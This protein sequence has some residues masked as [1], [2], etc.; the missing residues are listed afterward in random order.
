MPTIKNLSSS[1]NEIEF[2]AKDLLSEKDKKK[3]QN[4]LLQG[5]SQENAED[6]R[7]FLLNL[8]DMT[9][10]YLTEY[11]RAWAYFNN[12]FEIEKTVE[13]N[14]PIDDSLDKDEKE[15]QMMK[16]YR[17]WSNQQGKVAAAKRFAKVL[18]KG[19][20]ILE[21]IR[22]SLT[23]QTL[24][25]VFY[26]KDSKNNVK[27][28]DKAQI[29]PKIVFSTFG[30]SGNNFV[31][32]AYHLPDTV[33]KTYNQIEEDSN[34]LD[35][36]NEIHTKIMNLKPA[37]LN[38]KYGNEHNYISRFDSKDAEIMEMYL[39]NKDSML[40][41]SLDVERY[42]LLRQSVGGGGGQRST[43]LQSGDIGLTQVKMFGSN[44]D[45]NFLRQTLVYK[46]FSDIANALN[47]L[48]NINTQRLE[49]VFLKMF[50]NKYKS[51]TNDLGDAISKSVDEESQRK[52]T[53]LLN[54]LKI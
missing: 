44:R 40:L 50:T 39:Q 14:K 27:K 17:S 45:V 13:K 12:S 19:Q 4:M 20:Y 5:A 2:E 1:I 35:Y 32:L 25:T 28:V 10:K 33:L 42:D 53:E 49:E 24:E 30:A 37:Y 26:I 54:I 15:K 8:K 52:I 16:A 48:S 6:F 11:K 18:L 47:D 9:V 3:I 34:N 38:R 31:S 23:G 29:S 51:T 22:E 36:Q 43:M 21:L 7:I 41:N 46:S